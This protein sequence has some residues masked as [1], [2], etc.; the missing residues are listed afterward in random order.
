ML[1][2]GGAAGALALWPRPARGAARAA[3][4]G[5]VAVRL[6]ERYHPGL[7]RYQAAG[8]WAR[9]AA[10]FR[11]RFDRASG[12][13]ARFLALARLLGAIRCGHTHVNPHNQ[14]AAMIERHFAQ[15]ARLLPFDFEWRGGRMLVTADPHG[16]G[17]APGQ[18]VA[19][20]EGAGVAAIQSALL[21]L[22]RADGDL[23]H[24]RRALLGVGRARRFETFDWLAAPLAR[25]GPSV[26]LGLGG[27]GHR[28]VHRRVPTITLA[29]RRAAAP[30]ALARDA[31][32]PW[33]RLERRDGVAILTMPSWATFNTRWDWRG[34]LEAALDE[35]TTDATRGLV[36]DLR[37]NEGGYFDCGRALLERLVAA[38]T[39]MPAGDRLTRLGAVAEEDRPYLSSWDDSLYD[40]GRDFPRV[41]GG[42][43]RVPEAPGER[44]IRP[45]GRR[46]TGPVAVV[47][48]PDNA[49]AT[50]IFAEVV[51]AA[52]LG[53]LVGQETG[54]NRRGSNGDAFFIARLPGADLAFDIPLVA[55]HRA[56]F[57]PD[58]G[59]LPDV[60]VPPGAI[61][62]GEGLDVM[63]EAALASLGQRR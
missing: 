9:E 45:R 58:R 7:L 41:G 57:H 53:L 11:A 37:G 52:G 38:P 62:H 61:R 13:G 31:D 3:S 10:A 54:L 24:R 30:P 17:L 1:V 21:P 2:S 25:Y 19:T 40:I 23:D 55:W 22:T 46:F 5:V 32:Q 29:E 18:E 35:I 4:E 12:P 50:G 39:P 26:R 16:V 15:G 48:G 14:S 28:L 49:S 59:T 27:R 51:K 44:V 60:P 63:L 36:V 33:W 47:V 8:A 34:W 56:G 6:L 43:R 42:L 20:I